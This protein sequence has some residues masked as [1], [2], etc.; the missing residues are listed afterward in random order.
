MEIVGGCVI[1]SISVT[2]GEIF[3]VQGQVCEFRGIRGGIR[4]KLYNALLYNGLSSPIAA[5]YTRET[6]N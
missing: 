3:C 4:R 5:Y 2:N 1:G 6:G